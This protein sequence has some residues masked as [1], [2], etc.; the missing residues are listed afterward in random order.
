MAAA[1]SDKV[2]H[3]RLDPGRYA[4]GRPARRRHGRDAEGHRG[5]RHRARHGRSPG[6]IPR[7]GAA[8][9]FETNG[10]KVTSEYI[11]AG[12]RRFRGTQ[13]PMAEASVLHGQDADR[14]TSRRRPGDPRSQ[15]T[16]STRLKGRRR[17]DRRAPV[18]P[19]FPGP[20]ASGARREPET[21][22]EASRVR[23]AAGPR[24]RRPGCRPR[25][26]SEAVAER[27][28]EKI[29]RAGTPSSRRG[30]AGRGATP[31]QLHSAAAAAAGR[32]VRACRRRAASGAGLGPVLARRPDA[33]RR[34][35]DQRRRPG[36][37]EDF[38]PR[39]AD[40][41]DAASRIIRRAQR[42][43]QRVPGLHRHPARR[44]RATLVGR[45]LREGADAAG[46]AEVKRHGRDHLVAL[47]DAYTSAFIDL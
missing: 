10:A 23:P 33:D 41:G 36:H 28:R 3:G 7:C 13:T 26:G 34:A 1:S 14:P 45:R 46:L 20:R 37:V 12:R 22:T 39:V 35:A 29:A 38:I 42:C 40:R 44:P 25:R 31:E 27:P 11:V 4:A 30:G 16:I 5:L 21:T 2:P 19:C 24:L 15:S 32:P 17:L 47:R 9:A 18:L 6:Y 8:T 43:G